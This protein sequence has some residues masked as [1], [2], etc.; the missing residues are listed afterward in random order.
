MNIYT[1]IYTHGLLLQHINCPFLRP[2]LLL[3]NTLRIC[4]LRPFAT[5][6][7][8]ASHNATWCSSCINYRLLPSCSATGSH[9]PQLLLS[10]LQQ[11]LLLL[12]G[13]LP[14]LPPL[15]ILFLLT[16]CAEIAP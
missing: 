10:L 1:S 14:G 16:L 7:Y 4:G 3:L 8:H 2:T 13:C 9:L 11:L 6:S 15:L 5:A 12:L